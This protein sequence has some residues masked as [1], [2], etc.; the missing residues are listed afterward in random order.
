MKNI[1]L[2]TTSLV[3]GGAEVFLVNLEKLLSDLGYNVFVV[4]TNKFDK[5]KYPK[6]YYS[7]EFS[8]DY[9]VSGILKPIRLARFM[10]ANN[11]DL[12]IDNR[13]RL[14]A[15]KT[16]FY[17]AIFFNKPRV[18]I[19]HSY[20]LLSYLF[21]SK[22]LNLIFFRRYNKIVCVSKAIENKITLTTG[23]SNVTFINNFVPKIHVDE[24][25]CLAYD[26][27]Y[28]LFFGRFDNK[29]KD[30]FFLIDAYK[31]STLMKNGIK[32]VLMGDGVDKVNVKSKIDAL[33][34]N[35]FI[36]VIDHHKTPYH[37]VKKAMFTVMTSNYEG[38]PMTI[39]ESFSLSVPIVCTSF[40][41][42][43]ELVLNEVNGLLVEKNIENYTNALNRMLLDK[44]LYMY[45]KANCKKTISHLN[46]EVVS[47]KWDDL[48]K[49]I[50]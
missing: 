31:Q 46:S 8:D 45:C 3:N 38:F 37:V 13:A 40:P 1:L 34:L 50:I 18:K 20:N 10:R 33:N 23:L 36:E 2:F 25:K 43:E 48:I 32:L 5:K 12:L 26:F 21:Q 4:S 11:I 42:A 9:L 27:P 6:N 24:A 30:L 22:F 39:L 35:T 14:N 7:L 16:F 47:K 49:E 19:I 15:F 41:G 17:E 28:I 44:N 29:A